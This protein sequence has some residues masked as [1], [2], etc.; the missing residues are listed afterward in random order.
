MILK[1]LLK[2]FGY[3]SGLVAI[4]RKL[5]VSCS[6]A[7]FCFSSFDACEAPVVKGESSSFCLCLPFMRF[8]DQYGLENKCAVVS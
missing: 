8:P 1:K 6:F 4:R 7:W 3:A 2:V 5:C